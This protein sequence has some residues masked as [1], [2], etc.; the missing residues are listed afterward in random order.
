MLAFAGVFAALNRLIPQL[1]RVNALTKATATK[2]E[3][4]GYKFSLPVQ[5]NM[6][7][8]DLKAAGIPNA[9]KVNY[10]KEVGITVFP[11]GRL[12]FHYQTSTD[13]AERLVKALSLLIQ[14]AK[15]GAL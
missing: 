5:T 12:V 1:P 15:A 9:A 13:A 6:I 11:E 3:I 4:V 7:V 14:D 2:L 8:L 10:C